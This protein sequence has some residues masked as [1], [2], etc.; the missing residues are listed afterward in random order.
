MELKLILSQFKRN[1]YNFYNDDVR[2]KNHFRQKNKYFKRK[3]KHGKHPIVHF[4]KITCVCPV[5]EA[6]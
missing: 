4:G 5:S 3:G 1:I 6:T 2:E